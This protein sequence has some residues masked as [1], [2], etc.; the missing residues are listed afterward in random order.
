MP[1]K[2]YLKN[3]A[4]TYAAGLIP[5][6]E[7][8]NILPISGHVTDNSTALTSLELGLNTTIGTT[9]SSRIV[10]Q[11]GSTGIHDVVMGRWISEPITTS[12]TIGSGTWT[13]G[14]AIRPSSITAE[15][16]LGW[17]AMN[18]YAWRP[19]TGAVVGR[20]FDSSSN[21]AYSTA[22]TSISTT[23]ACRVWSQTGTGVAVKPGDVI[24]F[25]PVATSNKSSTA[26]HTWTIYYNDTVE[27]TDQGTTGTSATYIQIPDTIALTYTYAAPTV[28]SLSPASGVPSG[29]NTVTITGTDF[30]GTSQVLFGTTPA[31][32]VVVITNQS[33]TC[34]AP[35]GATSTANVRVTTP[36]G[37]SPTGA[38]NLYTYL[39][40]AQVTPDRYNRI[41]HFIGR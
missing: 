18:V 10:S 38:A 33:I 29:G 27:P 7:Q 39:S 30:K 32:S 3:T 26:V 22:I 19:A 13:F 20:F 2:L 37:T 23:T 16:S 1:T 11:T 35:A 12:A 14:Q 15:A 17:L 9:A 40:T 21:F 8:S 28:T 6:G 4:P 5:A 34:V 24:V 41:R 31:T 36:L 25:E